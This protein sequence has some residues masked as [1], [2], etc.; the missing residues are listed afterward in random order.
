MYYAV[1]KGHATGIFNNWPEAQAAISGYSG[2]EYKKFN[3]KEEA[4]AYLINR[5]LWVEKVA[6][7]NKD[8][9]LVAFT[10]GSYDKELNRYSYGV[11]IIL[12]DGTE[13]DICGSGSNK[14][15]IDS[16]NIIGEIFGVINAVDWAI[17]NG[18]EKIK[19]YHDYE[20]VSYTH[21]DV[22]KRQFWSSW[23][24]FC[25]CCSEAVCEPEWVS[26]LACVRL[27]VAS[28]CCGWTM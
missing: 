26:L 18:Y 5:D 25:R 13:P 27:T 14:E 20:A 28:A 24:V 10:D 16:D 8:G 9:Y 15:Y 3:T 11:A 6:A 19:I 7:D 12:P 21:L 23:L 17:S 2:A 22:Y 4:E 1:K